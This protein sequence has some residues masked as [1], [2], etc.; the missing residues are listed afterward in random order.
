MLMREIDKEEKALR[1][2][3]ACLI[4]CAAYIHYC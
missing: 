4:G 1:L 3:A 2:A